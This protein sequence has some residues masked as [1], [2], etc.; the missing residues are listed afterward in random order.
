[1]KKWNIKL[2]EE[3]SIKRKNLTV[4]IEIT[5]NIFSFYENND[6]S[7]KI[8][9]ENFEKIIFKKLIITINSFFDKIIQFS[10]ENNIKIDY[11]F[12]KWKKQNYQN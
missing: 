12:F 6:L 7:I 9:K 1:M 2:I 4:N 8:K 11:V 10:K 3:I 5:I